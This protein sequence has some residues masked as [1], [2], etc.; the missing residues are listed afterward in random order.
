MLGRCFIKG[1]MA[2][3]GFS[4]QRAL[5]LLAVAILATIVLLASWAWTA[6]FAWSS[7][8]W[9][10]TIPSAIVLVGLLAVVALLRM[11]LK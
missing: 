11:L 8:V 7:N 1:P 10:L 9:M 2:K 5:L 3:R 4:A 6:H